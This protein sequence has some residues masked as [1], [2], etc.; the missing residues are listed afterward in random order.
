[1]NRAEFMPEMQRLAE[2]YAVE[3]QPLRVDAIFDGLLAEHVTLPEWRATVDL[4]LRNHTRFPRFDDLAKYLERA[5]DYS[6]Q[7]AIADSRARRRDVIAR[8]EGI[9]TTVYGTWRADL[10]RTLWSK[11]KDA[12]R[13]DAVADALQLGVDRFPEHGDLLRA[14]IGELRGT[15]HWRDASVPEIVLQELR[16]ER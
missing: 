13:P 16:E 15:S 4:C 11:G 1:M 7:R 12:F 14:E 3:I 10:L 6:R 9:E 5:R 2:G 8:P